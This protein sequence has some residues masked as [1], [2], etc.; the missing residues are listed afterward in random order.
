M[1]GGNGSALREARVEEDEVLE[2]PAPPDVGGPLAPDRDEPVGRAQGVDAAEHRRLVAARRQVGADPALALEEEH[3]LVEPAREEEGPVEPPE[4][5]GRDHAARGR[6][7]AAPPRRGSRGRRSGRDRCA[8]AA[9]S[10]ARRARRRD[11]PTRSRS[12]RRRRRPGGRRDRAPGRAR[13][14]SPPSRTT[15]RSAGRDR[16]G[17][18]RKPAAGRPAEAAS[19]PAGRADRRAGSGSRGCAPRGGRGAAPARSPANRPA[20][21]AS[22]TC[23]SR[24]ARLRRTPSRSRHQLR[25][26]GAR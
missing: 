20:D 8:G 21:R 5:V 18:P 13:R 11:R 2:R 1:P 26:E 3:A 16:R 23:A 10:T 25:T 15:S 22:T 17:P 9:C 12:R 6:G 7:R 14:P 19:R 24:V 4:V